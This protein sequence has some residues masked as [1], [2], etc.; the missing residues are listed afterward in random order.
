MLAKV[1]IVG[2]AIGKMLKIAEISAVPGPAVGGRLRDEKLSELFKAKKLY[3]L[4][5]LAVPMRR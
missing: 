2:R 5:R 3:R 1:S 4:I